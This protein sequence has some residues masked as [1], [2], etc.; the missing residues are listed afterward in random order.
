VP[1][2][3]ALLE[4]CR[5]APDDDAPRLVWADAVGGERGELVV[6]QCD[7]AR[8]G[9][10]PAAAAARRRRERELLTAHGRRWAGLVGLT[11]VK[12]RVEFRRG[13]VEA[14][15]LDARTFAARGDELFRR[16]PLLRSVTAVGLAAV[17]GEGESVT[18]PPLDR[19][20][21]LLA[22]P[23]LPRLHALH[24]DGVGRWAPPGSDPGFEGVGDEAAWLLAGAG[25][26]AHLGG[27]GISSSGLTATG[28]R[29]LARPGALG[30]L[31][32][33]WLGEHDLRALYPPRWTPPD[34]DAVLA[35]LAQ[36]PRVTSLELG[37]VTGIER[38]LAALPPLT[39]LCLP[40]LT[41]EALAAL[42]R[43]RAA[44]TLETLRVTGALACER[45]FPELPRLRV[46]D[47]GGGSFGLG[48]RDLAAALP[49]LRRLR[50]RWRV[51][52]RE[53]RLLAEVLGPR[54]EE[55]AVTD[56]SYPPSDPAILA[57]SSFVAGEVI[58][59][60]TDATPALAPLI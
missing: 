57:L 14:V 44:P 60:S 20:R 59:R 54:L 42:G 13:F 28:L 17:S 2:L 40:G 33:L 22:S 27:F 30:D 31:E 9:L 10:P 49:A 16:A 7:L 34:A 8:G 37:D 12:R 56:A 45:A 1:D 50:L 39:A 11:S 25:A 47:L 24:L 18:D 19:L 41:D 52:A 6:I 21:E 36:V 5:R 38:V 55:L 32:R 15:E 26:L 58:V 35:L 48:A 23:A 3:D 4:A 29:R 53:L 51:P 46:L 43:G